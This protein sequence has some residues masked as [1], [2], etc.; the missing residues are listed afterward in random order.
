MD[1]EH[2]RFIFSLY[3]Y[4]NSQSNYT[5]K[6]NKK[7]EK[8]W[9]LTLNSEQNEGN[10]ITCFGLGYVK[11]FLNNEIYQECTQY[12]PINDSLKISIFKLKNNLNHRI[13][14]KLKYEL[15]LQIGEDEENKRFVVKL[16]KES[17]NMNLYKNIKT[18]SSYVYVTSNEK[19]NELNELEINLDKDEEKEVIFIV[20]C[21]EIEEECLDKAT[22]YIAKYKEEFENVKKYWKD[23]T[24]KIK[25]NTPL[26]SF[27]FLQNNWLVYQTLASRILSKSAFYQASR[28]VWF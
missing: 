8:S 11:Y 5:A 17:L 6:K 1:K 14:L 2:E 4:I 21:E 9:N 19:I 24:G 25:S 15:D 10:Y 27:D 3:N 28:R 16:Y 7:I 20:G 22:K 23:K 26:K 13:S 18:S 12:I